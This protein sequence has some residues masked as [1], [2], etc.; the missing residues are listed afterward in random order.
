MNEKKT[1]LIKFNKFGL[2]L[3]FDN[4]PESGGGSSRLVLIGVMGEK[5]SK[6]MGGAPEGPEHPPPP[7]DTPIGKRTG[8]CGGKKETAP[9]R[10]NNTDLSWRCVLRSVFMDHDSCFAL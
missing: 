9:I 1:K 2:A 8:G 6:V 10:Y 5:A 7:V 3:L 4:T